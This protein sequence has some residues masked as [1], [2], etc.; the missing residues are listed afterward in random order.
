MRN[1]KIDISN[2]M[3][4]RDVIMPVIKLVAV[5]RMACSPPTGKKP[6]RRISDTFY[7]RRA[8]S[9][10]SRNLAAFSCAI[11]VS[12]CTAHGSDSERWQLRCHVQQMERRA[13]DHGDLLGHAQRDRGDS[14]IE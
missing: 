6:K 10:C 8:A 9:G 1:A 4:A 13:V 7:A 11:G 3:G 14:R 2:S 12:V 5:S